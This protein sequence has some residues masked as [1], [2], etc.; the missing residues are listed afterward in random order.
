MKLM[1]SRLFKIAER[2][3]GAAIVEFALIL[4]LLLVLLFF[5]FE[6]GRL[7]WT[8]QQLV[9]ATRDV[10]RYLSRVGDDFSDCTAPTSPPASLQT[11][12]ENLVKFGTFSASTLPSNFTPSFVVNS[13][14]PT[15][16]TCVSE[17][18]SMSGGG[19][20]TVNY[21]ATQVSVNVTLD[22]P[23]RFIVDYF[24]PGHGAGQLTYNIVDRTR[25]F[26][27]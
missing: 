13:V 11:D 15:A 14:T 24:V 25:G 27:E 16:W 4:P 21:M 22:L 2:D 5:F 12:I 18:Y 17:Q 10:T 20:G 8:H 7:L 23:F 6:A 3:E 9:L 26:G 1:G 19:T